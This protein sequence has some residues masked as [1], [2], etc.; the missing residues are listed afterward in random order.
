MSV[1]RRVEAPLADRIAAAL[2]EETS[3][4]EI[5]ALIADSEQSRSRA[6]ND[7]EAAQVR[8]LDPTAGVEEACA[9]KRK[10]DDLCFEVDR[11]ESAL[12]ALRTAQSEAKEREADAVRRA[13]FDA[14]VA[15]RDALVQEL[16]EVY[17][18]IER[19]LAEL[20][21]RIAANN[22]T[23]ERVNSNLPSGSP[24]LAEAEEIARGGR[25]K[26]GGRPEYLAQRITCRLR[27][28]R[29]EFDPRDPDVW[30]AARF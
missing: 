10:A 14:A 2:R 24:G 23:L 3:S 20:V 1:A 30:P 26:F 17:P 18:Q 11:L 9:A 12:D 28:P 29:F 6:E 19:R 13:A 25:E 7:R 21:G 27:L 4:E 22:A 16:R 5:T 15:E 8:A